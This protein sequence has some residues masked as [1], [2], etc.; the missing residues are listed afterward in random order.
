MEDKYALSVIM[1]CY[2][3][4]QYLERAVNSILSQDFQNYEVVI[5]NDGSPDNLLEVCE[6][7][8]GKNNFTIVTTDNQGV[9]QARNEGLERAKGKYVFFMD[10]DDYIN[11]G[12]FGEVMAKCMEDEYDAVRFGFRMIYESRG[13]HYDVF[14]KKHI[15]CSNREIIMNYLPKF[16]GFGQE[17]LNNW[18]G[19]NIWTKREFATVWRFFYK[20]SV[21][22]KNQIRFRKGINFIEDML[23]N[24]LF[25]LHAN[26]IAAMDKVYYNYIIN[27]K[28]LLL[29]SLDS[30]EKIV[31]AKKNGVTERALLRKLYLEKKGVDI[32][33][34][35]NGTLVIGALEIIV[36]GVQRPIRECYDVVKSYLKMNDVKEAYKIT[37]LS[38]LPCKMKIPALML[39][40]GM[41]LL[42]VIL[43]AVADKCGIKLK[44]N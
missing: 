31:S 43:V 2:N 14:E 10:P 6:Q 35:Y 40:Y 13:E 4:A 24:S 23:F 22:M 44:A 33:K 38:G 29:G 1:P 41:T 12:M 34:Y 39:K 18:G 21:L 9:S 11:S 19:G 37:D 17:H 32:F 26:S 5:V 30:F 36:R 28:G 7:W 27:E 20:R 25:F 42:L 16:I 8:R 15:Y 3:V